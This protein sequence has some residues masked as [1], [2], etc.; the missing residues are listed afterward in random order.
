MQHAIIDLKQTPFVDNN[1]NLY[2]TVNIDETEGRMKYR[3]QLF[4]TSNGA[5]KYHLKPNMP[6]LRPDLGGQ[7]YFLVNNINITTPEKKDKRFAIPF[8]MQ[9]IQG[10]LQ[11][12]TYISYISEWHV[13][14]IANDE[15]LAIGYLSASCLYLRAPNDPREIALKK[16]ESEERRKTRKLY[17]ER[18][19]KNL[20]GNKLSKAEISALQDIRRQWVSSDS[21]AVKKL[22][23]TGYIRKRGILSSKYALTEDG[24]DLL[25]WLLHEY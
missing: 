20:G 18:K 12:I 3:L 4:L 14:F 1:G 8:L 19:F 13:E 5:N 23:A 24:E 6:A 15:I 22:L 10:R 11:S 25:N 9:G 7:P 16:K 17:L 2:Y 21:N